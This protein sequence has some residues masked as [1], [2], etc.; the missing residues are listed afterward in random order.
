VS[1]ERLRVRI[2]KVFFELRDAI[3]LPP[4]AGSRVGADLIRSLRPTHDVA[5]ITVARTSPDDVGFRE[6]FLLVDG[7]EVAILSHGESITHELPAGPHRLRAHNTL[8]W[9]THDIVLK[10]GEHARFTAVNRAGWGTF[11]FLMILGA[12]PLY[13]TFE[14]E[15]DR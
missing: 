12:A 9:K 15:H 10:P 2:W 6:V 8:F 4:P 14:R 7:T 11:G 5:C 1:G 13:L 3:A